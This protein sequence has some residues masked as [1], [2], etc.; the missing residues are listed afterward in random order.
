M[1]TVCLLIGLIGLIGCK[2]HIETGPYAGQ[3][4]LYKIDATI[5]S[6]SDTIE[7]FLQWE[8]QNPQLPKQV[9]SF[10]AELR[11]KAPVLL[12][13]AVSLRDL[14]QKTR[15]QHT[16]RQLQAVLQTLSDLCNQA[17]QWM[18]HY[19]HRT[20]LTGSQRSD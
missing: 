6:I 14:Y 18:E 1:A 8:R 17:I 7:T 5:A 2:T 19:E 12:Q 20:D 3:E 10:A 4:D 9:H 13:Q 16:K 11:K 15:G